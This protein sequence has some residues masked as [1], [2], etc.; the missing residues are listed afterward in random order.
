ME[1]ADRIT[2]VGAV[3]NMG[4]AALKGVVGTAACS[5]AL[6]A[7]AVHSLSDLVS[8]GV[9]LWALHRARRPP[10]K[11]YPYGH[12]KFEAV[13]SACVGGLLVAAGGGIGIHAIQAAVD[14]CSAVEVSQA[15]LGLQLGAA[16]V[17]A[18]SVGIKEALYRQ[19]LTV[20]AE[21]RSSTLAANAWHHRSDALSSVVALV[22]I[23]GCACGVPLLDPLAGVVVSALI[24]KEGASIGSQALGE[25]TDSQVEPPPPPSPSPSPAPRHPPP[26]GARASG[27]GHRCGAAC[28]RGAVARRGARP[29]AGALP[30]RRHAREQ[31]PRPNNDPDH[32]PNPNP[33]PDSNT[34]PH[35]D[36]NV[37][38]TLT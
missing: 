29:C 5:P 3:A 8:D 32:D 38:S 17:A 4:M 6:Q 31:R 16:A 10:D 37:P 22:G 18:L 19:T 30:A 34:Y 14:A 1:R 20:A 24:L 11:Y 26:G 12:G 33:N 25:L 21:V 23:G 7:D 15:A 27:R 35:L 36:P 13:G 28:A 2:K 9:S